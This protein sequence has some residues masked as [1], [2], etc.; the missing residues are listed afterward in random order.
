[1]NRT[2][3]AGVMLLG[4]IASLGWLFTRAAG[5]PR[6]EAL[7]DA[8]RAVEP[9]AMFYTVMLGGVP[10]GFASNTVDTVPEGL[11]IEDRLTLEVPAL[12]SVQRVEARTVARLTNTLRL[13]SFEASMNASAGRFAAT[14]AV[15]GDSLLTVTL[16][17]GDRRQDIEVPLHEPIVLPAYMPLRIAFGGQLEVGASYSLKTFDPLQLQSRDVTVRVVDQSTILVPDSSAFDSTAMEWVAARFDTVPAW[18]IEQT[19]DGMTVDAWID[20]F[21]RVVSAS[22]A[23]GLTIERTAFELAFLNFRD[24]DRDA[25]MADAMG[26][27]IIQQTAIASN[28]VL[29]TERETLRVV[30]RGITPDGFDLDGGRQALVADTL[31]VRREDPD[32]LNPGYRIPASGPDLNPYFTAEPLLQSDHPIIQAQ[33]RQIVGRQRRPVRVAR[34]LVDWV[35]NEV[36]KEMTVA[37]PSAVEVL[38]TKRGDCNEHTILFVS[39]A[40]AVGLPARTAAGLVYVDGSFYYHAW[41]EV[42]LGGWVAVDPTFGQFP[43]DAS[44]LRFTIGGLARQVELIRLIGRLSLEVVGT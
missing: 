12:G 1:M 13:Q 35:Y 31:T 41:A 37:I 42:Y 9:G 15:S 17:S 40:R 28:V 3:L 8:V 4:W 32:T 39:L 34:L 24:R 22:S 2:T 27:D 20:Q 14:G 30:M 36:D 5:G 10:I 16:H 23:M 25:S 19:T 6:G 44:H 43:A 11:L 26:L 21:G 18:R 38:E 29:G 7:G 33:A